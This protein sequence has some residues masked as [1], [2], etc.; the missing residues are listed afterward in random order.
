MHMRPLVRFVSAEPPRAHP[1]SVPR[2]MPVLH[3]LD[4]HVPLAIGGREGDAVAQAED[5][6]LISPKPNDH[7]RAQRRPG[8][9]V[10]TTRPAAARVSRG[11][12]GRLLPAVS[13]SAI[14]RRY[15]CF[16]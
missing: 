12:A 5:H 13:H 11:E 14:I 9:G 6:R 8:W 2:V 4:A 15:A 3:A 1:R 16:D 7:R 10:P